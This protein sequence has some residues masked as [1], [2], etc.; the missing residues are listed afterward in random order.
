[1]QISITD[2]QQLFVPA[3]CPTINA[4]FVQFSSIDLTGDGGTIFVS[5]SLDH[6]HTWP[7]NIYENSR[8]LK[9]KIADGKLSCVCKSGRLPTFR[10]VKTSGPKE[11]V[12]KLNRY[13]S[14]V[15]EQENEWLNDFNNR[16][17]R[18]HY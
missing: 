4:P 3:D 17:S 6:P 8:F 7:N 16:A 10:K 15:E 9:M 5:V 13:I 12:S 2:S 1:M 11:T 18:H 14:K